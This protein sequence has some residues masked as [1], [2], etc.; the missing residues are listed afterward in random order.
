MPC[1]YDKLYRLLS[2][3][4]DELIIDEDYSI[5]SF[6]G[7]IDTEIPRI[8]GEDVTF[9]VK[10]NITVKINNHIVPEVFIDALSPIEYVGGISFDFNGNACKSAIQVRSTGHTSVIENISMKSI[11][12]RG[13]PLIQQTYILGLYVMLSDHS[14]VI[15]R[16]ISADNL[17]STANKIIGDSC[18]NISALLVTGKAGINAQLEI[19]DCEFSNMHNYDSNGQ[20]ILEDT[21]GIY[22][23]L[24]SPVLSETKVHIHDI[25]G[26]DYGKRLIKTDCSNLLIENITASSIYHDTLSAIS[27]ND[28]NGKVYENAIIKNVSFTGTTQYVVGSSIPETEIYNI[29]SEIT[30]LP[31]V[32]SAAVIP[33]ESCYV[34]NLFLKGAQLIGCITNTNNKKVVIKNVEYDDTLFAHGLYGSTLFLTKNANLEL[35]NIII[36]SDKMSYLFIDN[37]FDQTNYDVNVVAKIENLSLNLYKPS[38]DYLLAMRGQVHE[39]DISIVNSEIVF[40]TPHKGLISINPLVYDAKKIRLSLDNIDVIYN[41]LNPLTTVPYGEITLGLNTSLYMSNVNVYNNSIKNFS[42]DLYSIYVKNLTDYDI[43]DNLYISR[44]NV[45][46]CKKGQLGIYATGNNVFW[47]GGDIMTHS[48]PSSIISINRKHRKFTY[49]DHLGYN[50]KWNG[51]RWKIVK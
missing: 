9:D 34:E 48:N 3:D 26:S 15:I 16:N 35:S 7:K 43:Y 20:I 41:D 44:C 1:N 14:D 19:H 30:M 11:D 31:E 13:Y 5:E 17:C 24:G 47:S 37:Y 18:G 25:K 45:D 32:Y 6:K 21:N 39:W 46:T 12:V 50:H 36:K 4:I 51:K 8:V 40:N 49:K 23:S 27:L 10:T 42:Y 22:V 38:F 28:A 2:M 29:Y 33:S